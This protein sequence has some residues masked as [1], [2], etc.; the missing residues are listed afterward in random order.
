M[1]E[2][3]KHILET[4]E[5]ISIVPQLLHYIQIE[6][7]PRII[8]DGEYLEDLDFENCEILEM[9]DNTMKVCAGGDWQE[10]LTFTLIFDNGKFIC[11]ND[12]I[13]DGFEDGKSDIELLNY[14]YDDKVPT[15]IKEK[16]IN[17]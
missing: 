16:F 4:E 3:L 12:S 11:D 15:N 13:V 1:K 10:P 6:N 8:E 14:I 5:Y 2:N 9:T 7:R 17:E